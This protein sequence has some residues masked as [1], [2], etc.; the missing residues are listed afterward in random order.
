MIILLSF[1]NCC[2]PKTALIS[3]EDDIEN[4]DDDDFMS[5]GSSNSAYLEKVFDK[6]TPVLKKDYND[7]PEVITKYGR[8]VL[9][10]S[11][12]CHRV[13]PVTKGIRKSL[14]VWVVGPK[15]K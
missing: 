15:F 8:A 1:F 2:S 5:S 14:V 3:T 12:L 9:F 4:A 13:K 7:S 6:L 10:P 11:F